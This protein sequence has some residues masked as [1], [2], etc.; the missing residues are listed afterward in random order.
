MNA[1]EYLLLTDGGMPRELDNG[2]TKRAVNC[3]VS[4]RQ[5]RVS[6][7]ASLAT[8][9]QSQSRL[10]AESMLWLGLQRCSGVWSGLSRS[11]RASKRKVLN[12]QAPS[13]GAM[14][15]ITLPEHLRNRAP[16]GFHRPMEPKY[17]SPAQAKRTKL[18]ANRSLNCDLPS[19][20]FAEGSQSWR[21]RGRVS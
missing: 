9:I 6:E 15:S 13:H 7:A 2:P 12:P 18:K 21:P 4:L 5:Q 8:V 10:R 19:P 17:R 20:M 16:D 3:C 1:E 14:K 11:S